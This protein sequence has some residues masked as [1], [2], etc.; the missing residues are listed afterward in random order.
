MKISDT[1]LKEASQSQD[2]DEKL[3][4]AQKEIEI[5]ENAIEVLEEATRPDIM[6]KQLELKKLKKDLDK[7]LRDLSI[8][9]NTSLEIEGKSDKEI[10]KMSFFNLLSNSILIF[11]FIKSTQQ[12]LSLIHI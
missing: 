2:T 4:R 1:S 10:D 5:L 9:H 11:A 7:E 12:K 3:K 8:Q 6:Q